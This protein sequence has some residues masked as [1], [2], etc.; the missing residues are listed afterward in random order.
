MVKKWWINS[1]KN[2]IRFL[3]MPD[4][5]KNTLSQINSNIVYFFLKPILKGFYSGVATT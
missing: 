4:Y 5:K 3:Y 2:A 1:I